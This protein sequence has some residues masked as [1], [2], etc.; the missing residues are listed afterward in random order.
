M[1]LVFDGALFPWI[2]TEIGLGFVPPFLLPYALSNI[3]ILIEKM[4]LVPV[5]EFN[6]WKKK[7]ERKRY[8][9]I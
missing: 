7:N 1:I 3:V 4:I 9:L 8:L 5:Y 6:T 2:L